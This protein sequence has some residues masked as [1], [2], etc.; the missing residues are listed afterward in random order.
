M[1]AH[2]VYYLGANI[3]IFLFKSQI[4]SKKRIVL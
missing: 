4:F 2:K 1:V 3:S